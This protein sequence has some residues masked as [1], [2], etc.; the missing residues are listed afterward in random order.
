MKKARE[1]L[2]FCNNKESIREIMS[3]F[4]KNIYPKYLASNI[5]IEKQLHDSDYSKYIKIVNKMDIKHNKINKMTDNIILTIKE[6]FDV[7][8]IELQE[9]ELDK[10]E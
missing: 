2:Y 8:Q 3:N 7:D 5:D 4:E 10:I 9:Q 1:S 6:N